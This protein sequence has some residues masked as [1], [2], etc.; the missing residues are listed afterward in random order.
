MSISSIYN[1]NNL[2]LNTLNDK[3]FLVWGNNGIDLDNSA[4]VVDV[5]MSSFIIPA[6]AG[7][8]RV[9]FNGIAR[10]WKVKENGGDIP[11][12]EVAILKSAIRTAAPPNGIY[13]MFISNTPNFD[14]TAQYRIM[15]PRVQMSLV[16]P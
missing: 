13:L 12:V 1:T 10:T 8:T 15:R 14:P 16:K 9:Q 2:N 7:G 6:I 5:D 4:V 3:E 11:S